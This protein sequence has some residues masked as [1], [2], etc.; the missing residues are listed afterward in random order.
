[1]INSG[2][3][4]GLSE[5]DGVATLHQS[6][7]PLQEGEVYTAKVWGVNTGSGLESLPGTVEFRYDA[8]PV[9]PTIVNPG[10]WDLNE[11]IQV[12][13]TA[14]D[15]DDAQ[16][17]WEILT[18]GTP[19]VDCATVTPHEEETLTLGQSATP[20]SLSGSIWVVDTYGTAGGWTTFHGSV[21]W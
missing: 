17:C 3:A 12:T 19:L 8:P 16:A 1:M 11:P 7:G 6:I 5:S 9:A 10:Q 13:L 20:T 14:N 2:T 15:D 21:T 4:T 18:G